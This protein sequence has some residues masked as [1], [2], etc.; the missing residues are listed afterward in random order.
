[1]LVST[2]DELGREKGR[3]ESMDDWASREEVAANV[4]I[5]CV[6]GFLNPII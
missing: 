5:R 2:F 4:P 1:M 3:V 6:I